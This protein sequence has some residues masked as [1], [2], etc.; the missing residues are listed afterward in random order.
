MHNTTET[1]FR[2]LPLID[3]K[4]YILFWE[5]CIG[6]YSYYIHSIYFRKI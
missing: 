4:I 3:D 5:S 1:L 6:I 2:Q